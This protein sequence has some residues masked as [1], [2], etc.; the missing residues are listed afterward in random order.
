MLFLDTHAVVW[1]Y[2]G[3]TEKFSPRG[4]ELIEAEPLFISPM[5]LLEIQ[6]LKEVGRITT[7]AALVIETLRHSIGLELCPLPFARVA[8]EALSET[9]TRDPFDRLIVA[10]ARAR[11]A[12][13]LTLDQSILRHYP[14]ARW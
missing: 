12:P 1:L 7:D 14:L 6:Y 9:W 13:L 4:T 5:V 2:A 3:L 10:Q 11:Q 8:I